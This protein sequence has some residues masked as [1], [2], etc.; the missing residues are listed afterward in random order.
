MLRVSGAGKLPRTAAPFVGATSRCS[1][2][3]GAMKLI[4]DQ[5]RAFAARDVHRDLFA[6]AGQQHVGGTVPRTPG[7]H[8]VKGMISTAP[9]HDRR[10]NAYLQPPAGLAVK[11]GGHARGHHGSS[12]VLR[13][14]VGARNFRSRSQGK[15][16][17]TCMGL[18]LSSGCFGLC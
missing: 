13:S 5:Q 9:R 1:R 2:V 4:R 17:R 3:T 6:A 10:E 14:A 11:A 18:F 7:I 12:R 16:I 8:Q 15:R